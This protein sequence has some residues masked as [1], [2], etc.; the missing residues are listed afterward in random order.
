MP[1]YLLRTALPW[2]PLTLERRLKG[3]NSKVRDR[4][5]HVRRQPAIAPDPTTVSGQMDRH[6]TCR[7]G[8]DVFPRSGKCD[9]AG[10]APHRLPVHK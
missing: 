8:L 7:I 2:Q 9:P 10:D 4:L 1:E 6:L 5:R 3:I